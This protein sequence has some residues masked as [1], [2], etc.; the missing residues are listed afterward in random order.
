M[1][2]GMGRGREPEKDAILVCRLS[3][4]LQNSMLMNS[5]TLKRQKFQNP[6]LQRASG[7]NPCECQYEKQ[8][9]AWGGHHTV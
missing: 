6:K 8:A 3:P 9:R 1:N 4:S 2:A 5:R 7:A